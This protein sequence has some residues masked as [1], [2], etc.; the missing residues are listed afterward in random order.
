MGNVLVV[1]CSVAAASRSGARCPVTK[2]TDLNHLHCLPTLFAAVLWGPLAGGDRQCRLNAG[3][4]GAGSPRRRRAALNC[5]NSGSHY[6]YAFICTARRMALLDEDV[7]RSSPH[8]AMPSVVA[9]TSSSFCD[10]AGRRARSARTV[11]IAGLAPTIGR[12]GTSVLSMRPSSPSWPSRTRTSRRGRPPL[13]S[14]RPRGSA[15]LRDVP[16][17][18]RLATNWRKVNRNP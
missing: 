4:P 8:V 10:S 9:R 7:R 17:R 13:F 14:S 16:G 15:A 2:T 5:P 1:S 6:E 12:D 3:R 11:A 18:Q